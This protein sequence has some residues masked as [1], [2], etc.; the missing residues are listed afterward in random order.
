METNV[1]YAKCT[2]LSQEKRCSCLH[3]SN[4][5]TIVIS[6]K[7]KS[8]KIKMSV[9]F[10]SVHSS[11]KVS[12][13]PIIRIRFYW[14]KSLDLFIIHI[15][16]TVNTIFSRFSK[17]NVLKC[18][19]LF[20]ETTQDKAVMSSSQPSVLDRSTQRRQLLEK[21]EHYLTPKP[22]E[23]PH[24]KICIQSIS[25]AFQTNMDNNNNRIKHNK[26]FISCPTYLNRKHCLS[27]EKLILD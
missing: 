10:Q 24:F 7:K 11:Q 26:L 2:I 6:F 23:I 27:G 5:L 13:H 14:P 8:N 25:R 16:C 1:Y 4:F 9:H 3:P 15:T 12:Q 20:E 19:C 17:R 21:H 18:T 22:F